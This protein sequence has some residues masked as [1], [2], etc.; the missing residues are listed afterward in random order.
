MIR[1]VAFPIAGLVVALTVAAC[2]ST[3]ASTAPSAAANVP[4]T[5]PTAAAPS[6]IPASAPSAAP[7]T[8]PSVAPSNPPSEVPSVALPSFVLPSDDKGLEALL[9]DELCGKKAI[10]TSASGKRYEEYQT[11][12]DK[13]ILAQLG[14]TL[15]DIVFAYAGPGQGAA[16]CRSAA[17]VYRVKGADPDKLKAVFIAAAKQESNTTYTTANIG[18]RDVYVGVTPG[19]KTRSY[20]YFIGDALFAA[21]APDDA[22]AAK[23]LQ[24][25]P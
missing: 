10:K 25:M 24:A 23:V 3:T 12:T 16:T 14:K 2:S 13:A 5:G 9:P 4:G 22:S 7:S 20:A 1:R 8:P 19:A 6:E 21:I 17:W 11:D 15:S 18:G